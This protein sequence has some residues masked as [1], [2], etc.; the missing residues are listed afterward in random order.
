MAIT[1]RDGLIAALSAKQL[2]ACT[3]ASIAGATGGY[4]SL[5]AAAGQPGA[6]SLS[7]GNTTSGVIPDDTLAGAFPFTNPTGGNKSYL[8]RVS[9]AVSVVGTLIIYDRLWHAGSFT[10]VNGNINTN[11]SAA[12]TR[13]TD[14][15]NVELWAE[16]NTGLNATPVTL[17]ATYTD[18]GGNN[19]QSATVVIPA[20]AVSARMFP[21]QLAAGDTG[22]RSIQNLAGSAAPTGNFNLVLLR[23]IAEIPMGLA[24]VASV[25]DFAQL[26]MPEVVNDACLCM[27]INTN[28]ANTG[29]LSG[30]MDLI[31]G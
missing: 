27:M 29:T 4:T 19:N 13:Y 12:L 30:S 14:G 10:A 24:G 3:K 15:A 26:G 7:I 28:T 31:Q 17:T 5:L 20:S 2:L 21:F 16:I 1:T 6:G 22:V 18:Q 23:R 11:G 9:F 25:L 8:A